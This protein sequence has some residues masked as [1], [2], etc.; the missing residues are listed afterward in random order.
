MKRTLLAAG[1]AAIVLSVFLM[2]KLKAQPAADPEIQAACLKLAETWTQAASDCMDSS[3][4]LVS[5]TGRPVQSY[6]RGLRLALEA[7]RVDPENRNFLCTLGVAYYRCGRM[8]ESVAALTQ[9]NELDQGRQIAGVLAALALAQHHLG[10]SEKARDNLRLARELLVK[11]PWQAV[12][13]TNQ[14]ILREAEV[15]ELDHAFPADP[16]AH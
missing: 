10:Q 8:A 12:Y 4:A 9:V 2:V 11:E 15:I 16:F 3:W 1:V 14:A 5:N 6:E 7:C 13:S